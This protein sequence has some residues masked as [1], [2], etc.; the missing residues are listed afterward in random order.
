MA[1]SVRA[2]LTVLHRVCSE[3]SAAASAVACSMQ[4]VVG[5]LRLML[6]CRA[7]EEDTVK[8]CSEQGVPDFQDACTSCQLASTS[9]L[10][11]SQT[12]IVPGRCCWAPAR[13]QTRAS[14][15]AD[16]I[17]TRR[18][19]RISTRMLPGPLNSDYDSAL[20]SADLQALTKQNTDDVAV[21]VCYMHG[22]RWGLGPIGPCQQ[23]IFH[24]FCHASWCRLSTV[25]LM[26]FWGTMQSESLRH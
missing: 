21:R 23:S 14:A 19:M 2:P 20:H 24:S 9:P 4:P 8:H 18:C 16:A 15:Q 17:R 26:L 7:G 5:Q 22:R 11:R 12:H 3:W 13:L 25:G 10:E 1:C 6:H